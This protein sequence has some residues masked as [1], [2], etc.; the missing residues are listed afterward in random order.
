[1]PNTFIKKKL[2]NGLTILA[3]PDPAAHT[4]AVGFFVKAGTRD[5]AKKLMGVSHFLEHMM[6]KT[7]TR[8]R[9]GDD[10]NREFDDMGANYNAYTSQEMTVYY[11]HVLPEFQFKAMD[12]LVDMLRPALTDQDFKMERPVILEEIGMY[13]DRPQW[14]LGNLANETFLG[15]HSMGYR[16]LGT[17][18]TIKAMT[19]KQMRAY[20]GQHY[21]PDT[22]IF[23]A[24]GNIDLDKLTS[25]LEKFT[26]DWKPSGADRSYEKPKYTLG[27][28]DIKDK[29]VNRH[30][31]DI[32]SEAPSAQDADRYAARVLADV[33]GD[34]EGSRLYWALVDPGIAEEATFSYDPQDKMGMYV[35]SLVCDPKR[36]QEAEA[37]FTK[38]L[39]EYADRIDEAELV[40]AKSKIATQAMLQGESTM[41]RMS[42]IGG[43]WTY[44]GEY[45]TLEHELE[46]IQAVTPQ[47]LRDLL[48]RFP[49][50]KRLV[51]TMS[52]GEAAG[53]GKTTT[54][55]AKPKKPA[56]AVKSTKAAKP[57][58]G[59]KPAKS[60]K[61]AKSVKAVKPK[62]LGK[63]VKAGKAVTKEKARKNV[64][65]VK[66][67]ALAKPS[68]PRK[69]SRP[70]K[71]QKPA[72]PVKPQTKKPAKSAKRGK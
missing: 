70:A 65:P 9:S 14:R 47:M 17:A 37:L 51:A 35:A 61:P 63:N 36:A 62:K 72:R 34:S 6:F 1:V 18:Q 24:A 39:D 4:S 15:K 53:K 60:S 27:R 22:T 3:E 11:A 7:T 2:S 55:A 50:N 12:L 54:K 38:T 41:G 25:E 5:E 29:K 10:I 43:T 40:R 26:R 57:I 32:L 67:R 69:V 13:D 16:V 31:C 28:L 52:P 21:G 66:P 42:S 49:L 46:Q 68:K 58:K 23:V 8:G 44:R 48:K 56:K 20:Y 33:L 64:K 19:A 59:A 45:Q 71:P 30:Y